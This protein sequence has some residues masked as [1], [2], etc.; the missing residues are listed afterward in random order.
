MANDERIVP[1]SKLRDLIDHFNQ[2]QFMLVNDNFEFPDLLGAAYEFLI[3]YF[4]DSA[5]KKGGQFYTPSQVVRLKVQLIKPQEGMSLYD[6]TVGSGG[7]LIQ[8]SQYVDEQGGDGTRMEFY[9]QDSDPAVVSIAKMNMILHNILD[10]KIEFGDTLVNPKN[11]SGGKLMQF[12]RVIANPPFS[13]NYNRARDA[14]S[15]TF[16]VWLCA[17]DR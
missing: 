16:C 15:R 2:P 6:P 9:G 10:A 13:Q 1:D 5:G 4:A 7:M 14:T 17:R 8:S 3:K 12:D 11:V